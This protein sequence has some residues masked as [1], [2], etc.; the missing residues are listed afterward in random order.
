M[1]T[2]ATP[3]RQTTRTIPAIEFPVALRC[4]PGATIATTITVPGGVAT[5]PQTQPGP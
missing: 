3:L 1:S 2:E 4:G 5:G